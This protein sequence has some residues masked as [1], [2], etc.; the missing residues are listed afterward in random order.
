MLSLPIPAAPSRNSALGTT[1]QDQLTAVTSHELAEAVTDPDVNY[2]RLGW[3]DPRLGEIGDIEER[4]SNALVRLDGYLVQEVGD[5][6]DQLLSISPPASPTPPPVTPPTTP[7]AT[8]TATT[9]TL[10]AGALTSHGRRRAPTVLMTIQV[11]P[12]SGSVLPDGT[13]ELMYNGAVLGT[14]TI[15][16]VNG[17]A[18]VQF[19]VQFSGHG[20]FTFTAAYVGSSSFQGSASNSVSV[21]V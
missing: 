13:V 2:G 10:T 15:Q 11:K 18:T 12:A 1:A 4:N 21:T 9:T 19:M 3:Y 5:K 17:V 20:N 8:N 7:P 14:G 6:N 16:I